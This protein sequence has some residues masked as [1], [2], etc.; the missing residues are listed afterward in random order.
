M[1]EETPAPLPE[2]ERRWRVRDGTP[3]LQ[4]SPAKYGTVSPPSSIYAPILFTDGEFGGEMLPVL[5]IAEIVEK[6]DELF[7]TKPYIY[8]LW[9]GG[10]VIENLNPVPRPPEIVLPPVPEEELTP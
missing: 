7:E 4:P 8:I 3:P 2:V 9:I 6:L 1:T 10:T 5:T